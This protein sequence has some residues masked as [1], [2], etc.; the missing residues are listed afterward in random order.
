MSHYAV[1][2]VLPEEPTDEVIGRTLAP[3]H[4]FECTGR[5]DQYVVEIDITEEAN[6]E[7]DGWTTT[8][9]RDPDGNLHDPYGADGEL[10]PEF[11]KEDDTGYRRF[12][13]PEG[14][15]EVKLPVSE[16]EDRA[17]W[18]ADFHGCNVAE[19]ES[20]IDLEET[21]KFG[22]VLVDAEGSV[23]RV[24]KRTNPNKKWDYW[25]VGGRYSGRLKPG[26]DPEKDPANLEPC[27]CKR[28]GD[29]TA[30]CRHCKGTGE[31]ARFPSKW[32]DVGN[33]ARWGDLDLAALKGARVA[34]R[35][36]MVERMRVDSGLSFEQFEIGFAARRAAHAI[37]MEMPEPRPRGGEYTE[38]L[39]TQPH[40][41]LAAAYRRA[42]TWGDIETKDGQSI[43]DWIA[44]A[45]AVSAYAI[46]IDGKW[47][48]RGEMGWFGISHDESD[49]WETQRQAI[50]DAIPADHYVAFVDC[51]I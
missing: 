5:N 7:Y 24:V 6:R 11:S 29:D 8:R 37:W 50:I 38:W 44:S 40:G 28:W 4:E 51:H 42:D 9:L 26:Y 45:P 30:S 41:D 18:I 13:A 31:T 33:R 47:C 15:E 27:H 34:E 12:H 22:H 25:T 10:K 20:R 21:H 39:R 48:S 17:T 36:A 14:Y 16:F 3:W 23:V 2:V 35:E 46:V 32:V 43:A 19:A 49:D 1:L